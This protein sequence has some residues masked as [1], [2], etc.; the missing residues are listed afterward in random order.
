ME[1]LK[2]KYREQA[3][4]LIAEI[5]KSLLKDEEDA[6]RAAVVEQMFRAM[7][8]LK[9]NSAMFGFRKIEDLTHHLESIYDLVR[10]YKLTISDTISNLT[11]ASL[12]H[13]SVLLDD[14]NLTNPKTKKD[15]EQLMHRIVACVKSLKNEHVPAVL[16]GT[17]TFHI[18]FAPDEDLLAK[19]FDPIF[20]FS[21]LHTLGSCQITARLDKIPFLEDYENNTCY[22]SW[23]IVLTTA[24]DQETLKE[25]FAF[26]H[27]RCVLE[28]TAET[29]T[30]TPHVDP[31]TVDD[32]NIV[33]PVIN[34]SRSIIS[35]IRV[36]SERLDRMMNM[37]SELM[38]LQAK[39]A[40]LA[41][42]NPTQELQAMA[43]SFEK[44]SFH[45]RDNAFE[46]CLVPIEYI[47]VPFQRLVRDLSRELKK[48]IEFITEGTATELDKNLLES[49]SDPIM[50][51]LRNSI[52]H[53]IELPEVR[54]AAGKPRQGRIILKAF[55]T[56]TNVHIEIRDDGKGMD[57]EQIRAKAIQSG[58]IK[59]DDALTDNEILNLVF[60][61]GFST[62]ERVSEVSGR[63]VGMDVV[64]RKIT[65]V[66]GQVKLASSLGSG[67]TITIK[68]PITVSIIDGLLVKIGT[69]DFIIPLAAIDKCYEVTRE[70]LFDRFNNLIVLE[71]TQVPLIRMSE[72]FGVNGNDRAFSEVVIVV[73]EDK[74][75]ALA[76]DK[77]V[78]KLQA[79]LKPLS[80]YYQNIENISGATILGDGNVALVLDTNKLIQEHVGNKQTYIIN[81]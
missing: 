19:G 79:V 31:K 27:D 51:I 11:L 61:P 73:W 25:I 47:M 55:C 78:R 6:N 40:V 41:D 67:S 69:G 12:D 50:H 58:L 13:L 14:E 26:L 70:S 48:E 54:T 33:E 71:G 80:Q 36:P 75:V 68:L 5:E 45:L 63:G 81:T 20:L 49:L 64:K 60:L 35:G 66:R 77:I 2:P 56:S 9:G 3:R 44:L 62:A 42:E 21:E 32:A 52:D 1:S 10:T 38:T 39:L 43:E 4:E 57:C 74:R 30:S 37:V 7:H 59:R 72:E 28:I 53:G 65:A 29:E 76:V 17:K 16:S 23:D 18:F 8:T 46:M 34:K 22:S 24:T 15:H